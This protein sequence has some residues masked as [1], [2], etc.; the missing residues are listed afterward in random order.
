MFIEIVNKDKNIPLTFV[1]VSIF[2]N[3]LNNVDCGFINKNDYL[4]NQ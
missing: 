4:S 1:Y 3:C 2:W